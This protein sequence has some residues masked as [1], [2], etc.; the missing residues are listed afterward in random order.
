MAHGSMAID[1]GNFQMSLFD[2][3]ND[4]HKTNRSCTPDEDPEFTMYILARSHIGLDLEGCKEQWNAGWNESWF[5]G[6]NAMARPWREY[7]NE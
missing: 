1:P 6:N 4:A 7:S 3:G 5:G 2:I